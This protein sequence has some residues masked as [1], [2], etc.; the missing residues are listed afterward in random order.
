MKKALVFYLL[1]LLLV[2]LCSSGAFSREEILLQYTLQKDTT[3][4]ITS[5]V[6]AEM[7]HTLDEKDVPSTVVSRQVLSCRVIDINTGGVYAIEA[8]FLAISL[9][10]AS[11]NLIVEYDSS[12]E[13]DL[14]NPMLQVLDAMIGKPMTFNLSSKG[15][16]T[17]IEGFEKIFDDALGSLDTRETKPPE[18]TRETLRQILG[19]KFKQ[20]IASC[21][22][23]FKADP[24]KPGESWTSTEAITIFSPLR[25]STTYTLSKIGGKDAVVATR[26]QVTR[27]K[28]RKPITINNLELGM[29]LE[30]D[31]EGIKYIDTTTGLVRKSDQKYTFRGR[32]HGSVMPEHEIVIPF[33]YQSHVSAHVE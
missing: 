1:T 5:N 20:A 17:N 30:G 19:D 10:I 8:R 2:F 31:M 13:S 16:I 26:L 4:T 23:S 12:M 18:S 22:C 21:F 3:F 15:D 11:D 32:I 6:K 14:K 33:T 27:E 28:D 24:V 25:F 29:D 9:S 7:T